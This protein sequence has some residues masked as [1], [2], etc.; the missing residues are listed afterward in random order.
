MCMYVD[1]KPVFKSTL[2]QVLP[3]SREVRVL[4]FFLFFF[5][6]FFF[7]FF[8][9]SHAHLLSITSVSSRETVV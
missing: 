4:A 3:K 7:L 8:S 2:I 1:H 9:L 5:D 6:V